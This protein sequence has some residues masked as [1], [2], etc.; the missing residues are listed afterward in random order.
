[1]DACERPLNN[2]L[3][4]WLVTSPIFV[5]YS[6]LMARK[7]AE[8]FSFNG[9]V[10]PFYAACRFGELSRGFVS[11]LLNASFKTAISQRHNSIFYAKIDD[12][13]ICWDVTRW[14]LSW[15]RHPVASRV[16]LDLPYWA[17]R[18]ALYHL[19]CMAIEMASK[20][21]AFVHCNCLTNHSKIT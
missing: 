14:I 2:E 8:L 1:M 9:G 10:C 19:I 5:H 7:I 16:A 12:H 21:G 13:G 15:L 18:W 11:C 3:H 4:W 20:V 17:M 6:R